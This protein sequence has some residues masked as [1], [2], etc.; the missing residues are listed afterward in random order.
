ME[1]TRHLSALWSP[2]VKL[3]TVHTT[4][5]SKLKMNTYPE[6]FKKSFYET[7]LI[8]FLNEIFTSQLKTIS[9][10]INQ[11][12]TIPKT[13]NLMY[14]VHD[15]LTYNLHRSVTISELAMF[16]GI[17]T[18]KLKTDFKSTFQTTVFKHLTSLRMQKALVL[19]RESEKSIAQISHQV[20][21]KNPQHF[22][23]A[24]KKYYGYLPSKIS[25]SNKN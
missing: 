24:F 1:T 8:E 3:T 16:A 23:V 4:Q 11:V 6:G 9:N 12:N 19:L 10:K 2:N 18:T 13:T 17:N 7:I 15:Y 21:Y 25:R 5:L 20:G 14:K 22:T